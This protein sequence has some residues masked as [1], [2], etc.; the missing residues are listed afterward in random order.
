MLTLDPKISF[1]SFNPHMFTFRNPYVKTFPP[2]HFLSVF[3][4]EWAGSCL[5]SE[6]ALLLQK[7]VYSMKTLFCARCLILY[8]RHCHLLPFFLPQTMGHG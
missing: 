2:I 4:R 1:H 5:L 7:L 8:Y 6:P 3:Y